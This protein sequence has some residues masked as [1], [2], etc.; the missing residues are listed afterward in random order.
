MRTLP[1]IQEVPA[2]HELLSSE[3]QKPSGEELT[4]LRL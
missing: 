3:T 1:P 2:E 4:R